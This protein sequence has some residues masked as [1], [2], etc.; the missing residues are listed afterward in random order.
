MKCPKCKGEMEQ[1]HLSLSAGLWWEKD[2]EGFLNNLTKV[3][4]NVTVHKCAECGYLESYV[5]NE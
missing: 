5:K 2:K 4:S 3:V 1:G